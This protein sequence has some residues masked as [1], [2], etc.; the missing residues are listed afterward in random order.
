MKTR[1]KQI[2]QAGPFIGAV[3]LILIGGEGGYWLGAQRRGEVSLAEVASI[4]SLDYLIGP[5]SFSKIKNAR[6]C[7]QGLCTQL[8]RS[9]V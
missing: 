4:P 3:I 5:E 7:L 2:R 1:V 9:R 6:N 8:H